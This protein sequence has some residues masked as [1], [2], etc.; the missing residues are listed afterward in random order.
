VP[1][2]AT[3]ALVRGS[4]AQ[5]AAGQVPLGSHRND[6]LHTRHASSGAHGS[7]QIALAQAICWDDAERGVTWRKKKGLKDMPLIQLLEVLVVVGLLL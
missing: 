3:I 5:V 6:H 7:T 1:E 2:R 4:R